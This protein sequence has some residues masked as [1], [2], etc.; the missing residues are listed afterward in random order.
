MLL[1]SVGVGPLTHSGLSPEVCIVVNCSAE[2]CIVVNGGVGSV[3]VCIVVRGA[4][5]WQGKSGAGERTW[6]KL[7][8]FKC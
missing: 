3:E 4:C 8:C 7:S 6:Y 1:S 5:W 2:V